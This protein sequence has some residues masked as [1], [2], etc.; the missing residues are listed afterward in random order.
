MAT[1]VAEGASM[2]DNENVK[3]CFKYGC[4]GCVSVIAVGLGL[5]FLLSALQLSVDHEP[6]F[7]EQQTEQAL[8]PAPPQPPQPPGL[9]AE[10]APYGTPA[11]PGGPE[12]VTLDSVELPGLQ[13]PAGLIEVDFNMGDFTIK[14]GPADQPIRV[15]SDFD[16]S[17]FELKE[18]MVHNGDGSWTYKIAFDGKGGLMGLLLGG[19]GEGDNKVEL[20]IPRGHPISLHGKIRMGQS[21]TDLGGLWLRDVDLQYKAGD[22]LLEFREPTPFPVDRIAVKGAM[23]GLELHGLGQASP[24][25]IDVEHGMGELMLDLQGAWRRD[26]EVKARF[27]MGECRVWLPEGV[28]VDI[29]RANVSMGEARTGKQD[30]ATVPPNAPKV[31]LEVSGAMGELRIER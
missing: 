11:I 26:G 15:E 13:G 19:G 2:S 17:R 22:H 21:R 8:P 3:G 14:P 7:Q 23:G 4:I 9:P 30:Q 18:E 1:M 6:A 28:H 16:T 10:A 31:T 12:A 20:I 25:R 29:R 27:R 24:R 5:L